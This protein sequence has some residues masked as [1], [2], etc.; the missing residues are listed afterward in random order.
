MVAPASGKYNYGNTRQAGSHN[1]DRGFPEMILKEF[2]YFCVGGLAGVG[3]GVAGCVLTGADFTPCNTDLGPP[4]LIALMESV[5]EVSM[6]RT[7][8]MV[9]ALESAVAAPRGPKAA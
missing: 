4:C 8:E 5:T 9:V 6:K 3:A 2:S 1:R 7:A